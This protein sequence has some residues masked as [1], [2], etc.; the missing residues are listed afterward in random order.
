MHVQQAFIVYLYEALT[1]H[2]QQVLTNRLIVFF[3]R[4]LHDLLVLRA[5]R[6]DLVIFS[7]RQL[8]R[9][10]YAVTQCENQSQSVTVV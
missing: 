3:L 2:L 9:K 8:S 4:V 1:A 7:R 6:R 5:L 10:Y